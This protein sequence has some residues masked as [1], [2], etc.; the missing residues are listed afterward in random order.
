MTFAAWQAKG[1]DRKSVVADPLFADAER[2]DFRLKP[3]SPAPS[4][5]FEPIDTSGIGLYGDPQ[6]VEG[7]K[8]I[9]RPAWKPPRSG[10][11]EE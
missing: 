1:R 4:I 8:K 6:W 11:L 5:G 7:P 2:F 10:R 3:G 9:R